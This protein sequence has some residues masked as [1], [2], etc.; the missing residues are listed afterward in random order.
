MRWMTAGS[1]LKKPAKVPWAAVHAECQAEQ[2]GARDAA[3]AVG[4]VG[5]GDP[6]DQNDADNLAE[7]QGDDGEIVAAQAQDGEAEHDAPQRREDAGQRQADPEAQPE[8]RGEQRVGVGADG[9]ECDV[10][11]VEQPSQ[12]DDDVQAPA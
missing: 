12:A 2:G 1:M 6:V 8:S 10:A 4:A 7:G 3:D 11:E 9:V 5:Q